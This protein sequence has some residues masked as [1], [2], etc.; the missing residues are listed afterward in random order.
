MGSDTTLG[1][2]AA[3]GRGMAVGTDTAVGNGNAA[4]GIGTAR[5]GTARVGTA[6]VGSGASE[7]ATGESD[8]RGEAV[9]AADTISAIAT[10]GRTSNL[11]TTERSKSF[12]IRLLGQ[13]K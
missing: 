9:H 3:L 6:A 2:G 8:V 1:I 11:P 13:R 12:A 4:L 7:G 5:V 10:S